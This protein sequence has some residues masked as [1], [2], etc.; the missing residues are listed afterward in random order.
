VYIIIKTGFIK[1]RSTV[2]RIIWSVAYEGGM[3]LG[4]GV[5]FESKKIQSLLYLISCMKSAYFVMKIERKCL[6]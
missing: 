4:H 5:P 2:S 6:I 1:G 3:Q